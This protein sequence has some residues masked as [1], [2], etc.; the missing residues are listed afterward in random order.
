MNVEQMELRNS[1]SLYNLHIIMQIFLNMQL[2]VVVVIPSLIQIICLVKRKFIPNRY[3]LF[4][5]QII[6]NVF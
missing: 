2:S 1:N 3:R 6:F 5:I 4:K